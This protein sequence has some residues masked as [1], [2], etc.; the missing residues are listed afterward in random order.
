MSRGAAR[1]FEAC[2]RGDAPINPPDLRQ[3]LDISFFQSARCEYE[4]YDRV[5]STNYAAIDW[6]AGPQHIPRRDLGVTHPRN[7]LGRAVYTRP[8][9][10]SRHYE[11]DLPRAANRRQRT[12]IALLGQ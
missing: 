4:V 8:P 5:T 1:V 2:K 10:S 12:R 11:A 3:K 9:L 6:G 7:R